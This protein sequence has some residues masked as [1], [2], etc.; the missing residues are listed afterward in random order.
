M[1]LY[2]GMSYERY[3]SIRLYIYYVIGQIVSVEIAHRVPEW[4]RNWL[5][6]RDKLC[7]Y[8]YKYIHIVVYIHQQALYT[9]DEGI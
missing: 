6:I 1:I 2:D 4:R 5:Y 3:D 8:V 9:V 7:T